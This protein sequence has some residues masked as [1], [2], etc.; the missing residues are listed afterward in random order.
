VSLDLLRRESGLLVSRLRVW[1]PPRWSAA[2]REEVARHLAQVLA[3]AAADLEGEPRRVLPD[4]GSPLALPD[5]L[6]VTADDLVRAGPDDE[7]ARDI[8]VHLLRH[9]HDLLGDEVPATLA[10][11]LGH[12]DGPALLASV[13]CPVRT[14]SD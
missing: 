5:Q 8:V 13:D 11:Q 6:A 9:R 2:G 12:D 4:L 3:D 14:R 10:R 1:T 7:A